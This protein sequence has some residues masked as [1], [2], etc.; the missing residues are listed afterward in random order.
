MFLYDLSAGKAGCE[1]DAPV[2]HL[3]AIVNLVYA[4][5]PLFSSSAAPWR[6]RERRAVLFIVYFCPM[7]CVYHQAALTFPLGL[8]LSLSLGVVRPCVGR[9]GSF[10]YC[11]IQFPVK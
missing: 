10:E 6:G 5:L 7:C 3:D 11:V 4:L 2:L 8:S 1:E 9:I